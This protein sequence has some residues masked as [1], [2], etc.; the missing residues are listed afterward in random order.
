MEIE[1][2]RL[3][4]HPVDS[5]GMMR[6]VTLQLPRTILMM[7]RIALERRASPPEIQVGESF[8]SDPGK[9]LKHE[10]LQAH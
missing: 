3:Q 4:A 7:P 1:Y 9:G 5:Q 6:M 10:L 8:S 2:L